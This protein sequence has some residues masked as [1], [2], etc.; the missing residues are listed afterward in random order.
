M[1]A[2]SRAAK[3]CIL[4]TRRGSSRAH[5]QVRREETSA[6]RP[7]LYGV[8]AAT[9]MYTYCVHRVRQQRHH[10]SPTQQ[11][12]SQNSA[13]QP[14]HLVASILLSTGLRYQQE[15]QCR[16][17][18]RFQPRG[19]GASGQRYRCAP[20]GILHFAQACGSAV[21]VAAGG[22]M[23]SLPCWRFGSAIYS[24]CVW[25]AVDGGEDGRYIYTC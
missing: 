13:V 23:F 19:W 3:T 11:Q 9:V 14:V 8:S 20:R 10:H 21:V 17:A 12:S 15:Q 2:H 1:P 24:W 16:I 4:A 25:A 5:E 7:R 22:G 6:A 18:G